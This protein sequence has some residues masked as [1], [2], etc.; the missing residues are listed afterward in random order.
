MTEWVV[1]S[2]GNESEPFDSRSKAEERIDDL[3]GLVDAEVQQ[4][5]TDGGAGHWRWYDCHRGDERFS[6]R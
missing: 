4:K 6:W 2:D 5:E 3:D 1:V